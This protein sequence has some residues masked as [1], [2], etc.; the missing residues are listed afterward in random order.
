MV[1]EAAEEESPHEQE[2]QPV[3][4][5]T[6]LQAAYDHQLLDEN[7][8]PLEEPVDQEASAS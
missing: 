7:G 1:E 4:E 8:D 5:E 2:E 6:G 3:A